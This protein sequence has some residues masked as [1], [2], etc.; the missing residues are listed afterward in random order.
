MGSR[1]H[2]SW[3]VAQNLLRRVNGYLVVASLLLLYASFYLKLTFRFE[4]PHSR[5]GES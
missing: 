3:R 2:A 1:T 4:N 5:V